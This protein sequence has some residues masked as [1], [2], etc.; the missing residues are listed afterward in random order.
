MSLS[1]RT[2]MVSRPSRYIAHSDFWKDPGPYGVEQ[3]WGIVGGGIDF[4]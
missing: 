2:Q 1:L 4:L 3:S